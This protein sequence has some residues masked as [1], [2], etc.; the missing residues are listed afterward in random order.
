MAPIKSKSPHNNTTFG[1][2]DD[3]GLWLNACVSTH[4]HSVFG[5]SQAADFLKQK[6]TTVEAVFAR[7]PN[8]NIPRPPRSLSLSLSIDS[9][10]A[11]A[12]KSTGG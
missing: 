2:T 10:V 5:Y 4:H 11:P 3:F 6:N 9:T 7:I 8:A 1:L 12:S